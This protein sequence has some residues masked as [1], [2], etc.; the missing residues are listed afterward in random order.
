MGLSRQEYWSGLPFSSPDDLPNPGIE[1]RSPALQTDSLLS[2]PPG[3]KPCLES[4]LIKVCVAHRSSSGSSMNRVLNC[5]D[6]PHRL[7]IQVHRD[8]LCPVH[9]SPLG[10]LGAWGR[11]S[12]SNC[13]QMLCLAIKHF[14]KKSSYSN[15]YLLV[16]SMAREGSMDRQELGL[17]DKKFEAEPRGIQ[18]DVDDA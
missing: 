1:P 8:W 12:V 5:E 4:D 18:V 14:K 15:I 2:E 7:K 3:K 16:N 9:W 13:V 17:Q 10:E 11:F 6:Q